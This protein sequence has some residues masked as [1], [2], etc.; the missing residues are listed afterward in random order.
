MDFLEANKEAIEQAIF[1]RVADLLNLDIEVIF[2][3]TTSLHFEIDEEDQRRRA[4]SDSRQPSRRS[5]RYAGA[6]ASAGTARTGAAT[7]RK[8]WSAW[9]SRGRASRCA[10]GCFRAI[11]L[12]SPRSNR[13]KLTCGAGNSRAASSWRCRDGLG[14]QPEA[15]SRGGG[16][17][18]LACRCAVATRLPRKFYPVPGRYRAWPRIWRSRKSL[19]AMASDNAA[20]RSASTRM[21]AERQQV[22]SEEQLDELEAELASL[23]DRR[24]NNTANGSELRTSARY[25]RLLKETQAG[26]WRSTAKRDA[27]GTLR[28]QVRGA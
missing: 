1:Y 28:R 17:Y 14:G 24:K 9:P 13:S 15:L 26:I 4:G 5:K 25:G 2:Y 8:S 3:D 6:R 11:P 16:K 7:C 23:R 18:L 19:S 12:T 27:N 22:A 10:T 21:E 20:T